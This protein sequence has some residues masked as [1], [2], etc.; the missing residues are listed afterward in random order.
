MTEEK[1]RGAGRP[2]GSTSNRPTRD[3]RKQ[4]RWTPQEW[5]SIESAAQKS[6]KTVVKWQR[7]K[8]L[9]G[10]DDE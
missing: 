9:K 10:L 3:I 7:D 8:L 5:H 4:L 2:P 6:G 1:K